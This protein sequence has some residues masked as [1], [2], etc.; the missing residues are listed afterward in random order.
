MA[1]PEAALRVT[2]RGVAL[3]A[4]QGFARAGFG[5]SQDIWWWHSRALAA[6][7]RDGDAWAALQRAHGLLLEAVANVRDAGLRRSYLNKLEVNR[8]IVTAWLAESA[9]HG[10]DDA[11][12]AGAPRAAE[13]R[14]RAFPAPRRYRHAHERAA[15][16]R[17]TARL[18]DR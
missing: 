4:E 8:G 14:G 10:V 6:N 3:H 2:T 13:Q 17:R 9:S 15:Q 5:Q 11:A 18:P 7:A 1:T 12:A 16:H